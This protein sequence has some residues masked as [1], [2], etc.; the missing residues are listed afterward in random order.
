MVLSGSMV[1]VIAAR[2]KPSSI[3]STGLMLTGLLIAGIAAAGN[4]IVLI[5]IIFGVGLFVTPVQASISTILQTNVAN[6]MRGRIGAALNTL[7]STSS[8]LSMAL[9]GV[10]AEV[11]GVRNVFV[12]G[13]GL[14]ILAGI[15]SAV[16]FRPI[17]RRAES[18]P[19]PNVE[20][21]KQ[22]PAAI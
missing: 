8:L 13:G 19:A 6:E 4:I 14:T 2:L 7:V 17:G 10:L 12:L 1:A 22:T 21:R 15:A 3:I 11:V 16:V 9:A 20:E 5:G 18:E